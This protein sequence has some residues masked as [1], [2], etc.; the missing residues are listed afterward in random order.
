MTGLILVLA[1]ILL[2]TGAALAESAGRN[3]PRYWA[4]IFILFFSL[5]LLATLAEVA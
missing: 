3:S 4:W 1:L 5:L 2:G